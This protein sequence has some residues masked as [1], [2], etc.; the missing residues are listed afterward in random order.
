MTESTLRNSKNKEEDVGLNESAENIVELTLNLIQIGGLYK[1]LTSIR[2]QFYYVIFWGNPYEAE[3]NSEM[4]E[5]EFEEAYNRSEALFNQLQTEIK[6][7]RI[8]I[9]KMSSIELIR[10]LKGIKLRD[11][12]FALEY[13]QLKIVKSVNLIREDILEMELECYARLQESYI[14]V[15]VRLIE[16]YNEIG[17]LVHLFEE[18]VSGCHRQ[19]KK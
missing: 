9:S 12:K 11:F 3:K 6:Q 4:Y 5:E 8:I 1:Q 17:K 15:F 13:I 10:G 2:S 18:K 7:Q 14:K 16:S 19:I